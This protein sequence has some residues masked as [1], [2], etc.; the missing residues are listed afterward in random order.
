MP[1]GCP[2]FVFLALFEEGGGGINAGFINTAVLLG[3]VNGSPKNLFFM[4]LSCCP[5]T[6]GL[7]LTRLFE[8]S[9][10]LLTDVA[11]EISC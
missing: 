2:A 6:L 9:V 10:S 3:G 11:G 1:V 7:A 4:D 8:L 5:L